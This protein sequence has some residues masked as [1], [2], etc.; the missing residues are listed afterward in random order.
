LIFGKGEGMK[1]FGIGLGG[2]G[3]NIMDST[4]GAMRDEFVGAVVFNT[5]EADKAKLSFLKDRFY[6]FGD[7][8]GAGVGSKWRDAR[9]SI[10]SEK[11]KS[12]V[13]KTI[14]EQGIRNSQVLL[15]TSSSGGGTG[16]G[17]IPVVASYAKEL[18]SSDGRVVQPVIAAMVLPFRY[19][20]ET[21]RFSYNSAIGLANL[22]DKVDSIILFDN[23]YM[24]EK[25][26]KENP[27]ISDVELLDRIN[28]SIAEAIRVISAASETP[29]KGGFKTTFDSQDLKNVLSMFEASYVVPCY[30]RTRVDVLGGSLEFLVEIALEEGRF[31][32]VD[33]K[34]ALKAAFVVRGPEDLMKTDNIFSAKSLLA[35]R[36]AGVDVREGIAITPPDSKYVEITILLIEPE[37]PRIKELAEQASVY[38]DLFEEDL[39]TKENTPREEFEGYLRKLEDHAKKIAERKEKIKKTA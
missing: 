15:L 26:V 14:E 34:T 11:W 1:W 10:S 33:P 2:A 5:A 38:Y 6:V 21:M 12:L 36:I 17:S 9:D 31:V 30:F 16:S 23:G 19:P 25:I 32:D 35:E 18:L 24:R 27:E 20:M 13:T 8:G 29:M 37:V 3:G 28:H 7:F 22:L 4:Y 39:K